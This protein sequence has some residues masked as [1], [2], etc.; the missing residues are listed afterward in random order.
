MLSCVIVIEVLFFIVPSE[1]QKKVF[2]LLVLCL[3]PPAKTEA[4][5]DLPDVWKGTEARRSQ[6]DR[7]GVSEPSVLVTDSLTG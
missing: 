1:R 6:E 5:L 2:I 4:L 7:P 3:Q